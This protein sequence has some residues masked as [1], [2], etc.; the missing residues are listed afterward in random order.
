MLRGVFV[1]HGADWVYHSM[2]FYL[3]FMT[4]DRHYSLWQCCFPQWNKRH[5]GDTNLD[6]ATQAGSNQFSLH[7]L[8]RRGGKAF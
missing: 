6:L 8:Q 3:M 4:T 5:W 1:G 2:G 7:L